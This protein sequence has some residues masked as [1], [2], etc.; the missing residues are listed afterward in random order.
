[1]TFQNGNPITCADVKYGVSRTFATDVITDGPTYAISMLDVPKDAAG[2]SVYKGPYVTKNNNVA[3]FDKAVQCSADNKTITFHLAK[4]V[5]DFNYTVTLLAFS[6]VPK[7]SDDAEKYDDHPVAS[8]PYKIQDYSK[9]SQLVLVR[10]D[11]WNAASDPYRKAYP[12]RIVVSFGIDPSAI[13]QRI[14]ADAG[15]DQTAVTLAGMEPASLAA[16]FNDQRFANRR[17]NDYDPY[18]RY[19]AINTV[20]V[21]NLKHRQAIAAALDRAQLLTIAGGTFAG[22]LADGLIKPNLPQ[23]YQPTGMWD[24]LLGQKIPNNGDPAYAKKLIAASGA[25]MP[26]ITYD[27][28]Q[29]PT[30]DKAAGAIVSS[31]AKAGITVK[32][33][34]IEAGQFY[35]VVLDPKKE[36]ELVSAGWGPDWLNASTVVP[37]LLTPSGGFNLSRYDNKAFNAQVDQAKATVDRVAQG[38]LW[39]QL[40]TEAMKDVPVVPTRFGKIQYLVGSKVGGAFIWAPYGSIPFGNLWVKG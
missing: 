2:N 30:N 23:D 31:L 17:F 9:G 7:A 12:D 39:A 3:A 26:A 6:P 20:K 13:D 18:V 36:H 34:P 22:D 21:P 25:P 40:N 33:N 28:P 8:G 35:G 10:N 19:L 11:K 5:A 1:V 29:S 24:T 32:P 14:M 27:Y 4:P 15:G 16:V 37:E 38:K